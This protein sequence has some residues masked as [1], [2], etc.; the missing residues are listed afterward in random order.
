MKYRLWKMG[1]LIPTELGSISPPIYP[2]Q[3]GFFRCSCMYTMIF[4]KW[5][6][7]A[8]QPSSPR[9]SAA[10][11]AR[12]LSLETGDFEGFQ[13]YVNIGF[14]F[15]ICSNAVSTYFA[16]TR[17]YSSASFGSI[18]FL[19]GGFSPTHFKNMRTVKLDHFPDPETLE[20]LWIA[21]LSPSFSAPGKI[22]EKQ[23]IGLQHNSWNNLLH[24][25]NVSYK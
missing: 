2:K 19:V 22:V 1:I 5:I 18:Y 13:K 25:L 11:L 21:N 12:G 15:D 20:P 9:T 7:I 6:P 23:W 14:N 16:S 10:T 4:P 3:P 17:A 8:E 24:I